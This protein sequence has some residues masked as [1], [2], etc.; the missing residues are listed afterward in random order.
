MITGEQKERLS[1]LQVQSRSDFIERRLHQCRRSV[2]SRRQ[3]SLDVSPVSLAHRTCQGICLSIRHA[4]PQ[5]SND[6]FA[7]IRATEAQWG[8]RQ[9]AQGRQP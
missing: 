6:R 5:L 2:R 3:S 8:A 7:V 1:S 9:S 4:A